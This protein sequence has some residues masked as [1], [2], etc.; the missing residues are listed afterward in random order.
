M[1]DDRL[2]ANLATLEDQQSQ[3]SSLLEELRQLHTQAR[4][5]QDR[6]YDSDGVKS[7]FDK[8][9]QK[10]GIYE[11]EFLSIVS[12][13]RG[14]N[15]RCETVPTADSTRKWRLISPVVQQ[16]PKGLEIPVGTNLVVERRVSAPAAMKLERKSYSV[17]FPVGK[18]S[19]LVTG[20][21]CVASL[22][23]PREARIISARIAA[24]TTAPV[25]D[26][27]A[28]PPAPAPKEARI[29]SARTLLE[30]STIL[31]MSSTPQHALVTPA[32]DAS[33]AGSNIPTVVRMISGVDAKKVD[34]A[35][36]TGDT[37]PEPRQV[38]AS[39]EVPPRRSFRFAVSDRPAAC[40]VSP[41]RAG[42]ARYSSNGLRINA[43]L[44]VASA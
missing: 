28:S 7:F 32:R 17:S 19:R 25:V 8:S 22:A 4:K 23:S 10:A 37:M 30:S 29:I 9:L 16:P 35:G 24:K 1:L 5:F 40:L 20:V 33:L 31:R 36:L 43:A 13:V 44:P 26:G 41:R 15:V 38:A 2:L 34:N 27:A 18:P 14:N 3:M 42:P 12:Q 11:L 39:P 21:D 6:R